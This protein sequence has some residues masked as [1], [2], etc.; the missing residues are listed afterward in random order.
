MS[1]ARASEEGLGV[2]LIASSN[3]WPVISN[4]I[5]HLSHSATHVVVQLHRTGMRVEQLHSVAERSLVH[6]AALVHTLA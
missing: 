2:S 4:S 1:N 6:C 5:A 3:H